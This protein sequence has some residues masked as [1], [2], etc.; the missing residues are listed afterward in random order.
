LGTLQVVGRL[1][2]VALILLL[3]ASIAGCHAAHGLSDAQAEGLCASAAGRST[4]AAGGY[5]YSVLDAATVRLLDGAK[6]PG[7]AAFLRPLGATSQVVT[8]STLFGGGPGTCKGGTSKY[9]VTPD[10]KSFVY[11]CGYINDTPIPVPTT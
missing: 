3:G 11:P 2:A 6:I 7:L 1:S 8:C 10:Q 5:A 9:L 4:G